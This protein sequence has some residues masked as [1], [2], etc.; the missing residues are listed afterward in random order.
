MAAALLG[1]K[2]A[3]DLALYPRCDQHRTRLGQ[4][5]HPRGDVGRIAENLARRIHNHRTGIEADAGAE[6]RLVGGGVP[7]VEFDQPA[8]DGERRPRGTL[9]VVLLRHRI[10]EQRHQ[11]V[12]QLLGDV[13]AHFGHGCRGGVEIG[14]DEVTP[15]LGVEL[16][17]NAGR[18]HQITE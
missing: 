9:R 2:Q 8:L 16:S 5:L 14:A 4:R 13:P 11:P 1:D 17:G 15:L 10:A 18:A 6:R 12:A 3:G 7:A